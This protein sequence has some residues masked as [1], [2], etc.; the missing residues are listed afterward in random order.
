[1]TGLDHGRN[2]RTGERTTVLDV[3]VGVVY[4]KVPVIE[5][6]ENISNIRD[7]GVLSLGVKGEAGQAAGRAGI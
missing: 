4:V 6:K 1:M 2:H 5:S 3:G 7:R